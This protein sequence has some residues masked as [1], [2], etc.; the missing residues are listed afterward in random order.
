MPPPPSRMNLSHS[1]FSSQSTDPAT[2]LSFRSPAATPAS[3]TR[4]LDSSETCPG[5]RDSSDLAISHWTR[6]V[7]TLSPIAQPQFHSGGAKSRKHGDVE[8]RAGVPA[9]D[10]PC[11]QMQAA[12]LPLNNG[13]AAPAQCG[14]SHM[15]VENSTTQGLSPVELSLNVPNRDHLPSLPGSAAPGTTT[16]ARGSNA[17][18]TEP[19]A[20]FLRSRSPGSDVCKAKQLSR[21]SAFEQVGRPSA[22][23]IL[24]EGGGIPEAYWGE[25]QDSEALRLHLGTSAESG[26]WEQCNGT[27]PLHLKGGSAVQHGVTAGVGWT[28]VWQPPGSSYPVPSASVE[29]HGTEKEGVIVNPGGYSVCRG[30]KSVRDVWNE[31][32]VGLKGGPPVEK[33]EELRR[34]GRLKEWWATPS[35]HKYW[36]KQVCPPFTSW[37]ALVADWVCKPARRGGLCFDCPADVCGL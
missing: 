12:L 13:L 5:R 37:L 25:V 26:Q 35:D 20:A 17:D 19:V 9:E 34:E 18:G 30:S 29:S 31:W 21:D 2:R 24:E 16:A 8:G 11:P 36:S 28:A 7:A 32:R 10:I 4:A 15:A 22:V 6:D 3:G 1:S 23:A 27:E 14:S 33:L